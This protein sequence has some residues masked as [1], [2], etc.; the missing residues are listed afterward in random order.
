[1]FD[2]MT[3][4]LKNTKFVIHNQDEEPL[5]TVT[6]KELSLHPPSDIP[7]NNSTNS[8]SNKN[9]NDGNGTDEEENEEEDEN[10][11][12]KH[13]K[14]P[15]IATPKVTT[16]LVDFEG[17]TIEITPSPGSNQRIPVVTLSSKQTISIQSMDDG[18]GVLK[19]IQIFCNI[20]N[21]EL[22]FETTQ[23][24]FAYILDLVKQLTTPTPIQNNNS[25]DFRNAQM[26]GN[27]SLNASLL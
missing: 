19:A 23:A 5:A 9:Q 16:K 3:F 1:M 22:R 11:N 20:T 12:R 6:L 7:S 14:T 24:E 4:K 21:G 15:P 26:W 27:Q 18:R 25:R 13:S 17:L 8:N 2:R 10:N